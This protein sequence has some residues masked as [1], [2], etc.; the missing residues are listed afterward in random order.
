[1]SASY[2]VNQPWE[3][4]LNNGRFVLSLESNSYD[5]VAPANGGGLIISTNRTAGSRPIW[6]ANFNTQFSNTNATTTGLELDMVNAS[7]TPLIDNNTSNLLQLN[8]SLEAVGSTCGIGTTTDGAF[9]DA[10]NYVGYLTQGI[11]LQPAAGRNDDIGIVPPADDMNL[12]IVGRNHANSTNVWSIADS[13]NFYST[14]GASFAGSSNISVSNFFGYDGP[15]NSNSFEFNLSGG[16][17]ETD[18]VNNSSGGTGG[19]FTWW[20]ATTAGTHGTRLMQMYPT[21]AIYM[22]GL[23]WNGGA[24]ILSSNNVCQSNG[25]NCGTVF[26]TPASSGSSCTQGQ[27]EF[28]AAYLYTCVAANTWRRVA[29]ASF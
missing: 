5:G 8:C 24:N 28:D 29:T 13:G 6:G 11:Y 7:P 4:G 16:G 15:L 17:S 1:M 21:S 27:T 22:P 20:L 9:Q 25:T 3:Y 19:G 2:G 23:S 26:G 12:E 10:A 14:G 18:F